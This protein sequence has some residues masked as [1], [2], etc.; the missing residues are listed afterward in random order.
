MYL[1]DVWNI[2]YDF[3]FVI[4]FVFFINSIKIVKWKIIVWYS[5]VEMSFGKV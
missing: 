3:I 5:V 4:V 2:Y 1:N